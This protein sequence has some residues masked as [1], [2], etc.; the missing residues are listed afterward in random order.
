[1]LGDLKLKYVT[2]THLRGLYK[3]KL[4]SLRP[5]T[6]QYVHVTMHKALKQAVNDGLIPRNPTEAVKPP[7]VRREEIRPL[8]PEQVKVLFKASQGDHLEALYVLAVHTGLR[9]GELLALK[10]DDVNLESATL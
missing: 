4:R 9:Q 1:V 8:S 6:V 2:S 7:R 5:R 10:C 3:E